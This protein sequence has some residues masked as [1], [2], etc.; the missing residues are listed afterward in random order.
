VVGVSF[1]WMLF[2]SWKR[3]RVASNS[4]HDHMILRVDL[5][6]PY[7]YQCSEIRPPR[8]Q[9]QGRSKIGS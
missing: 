9:T 6:V 2:V 8:K 1:R 3:E 5:V 4:P 7:S